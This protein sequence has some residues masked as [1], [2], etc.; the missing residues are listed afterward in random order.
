MALSLLSH[1][2]TAIDSHR[3]RQKGV[4]VSAGHTVPAACPQWE[5]PAW[6]L[7][8][9]VL[10]ELRVFQGEAEQVVDARGRSVPSAVRICSLWVGL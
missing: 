3:K 7:R 4:P 2:G 6:I 5:S 1:S 9:R 8:L 10:L